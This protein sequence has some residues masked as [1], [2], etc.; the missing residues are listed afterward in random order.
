MAR[1]FG[2][3][4]INLLFYACACVCV[5]VYVECVINKSSSA[6]W[7]VQGFIY[8][9]ALSARESIR[10]FPVGNYH[11][12]TSTLPGLIFFKKKSYWADSVEQLL[13]MKFHE[14]FKKMFRQLCDYIINCVKHTILKLLANVSNVKKI[15]FRAYINWEKVSRY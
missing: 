13:L 12:V 8:R 9:R 5:C 6:P 14:N 7:L 1:T 15:I 11:E 4:G 2:S 3:P 10:V